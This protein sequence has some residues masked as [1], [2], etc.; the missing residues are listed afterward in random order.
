MRALGRGQCCAVGED[1]GVDHQQL[2]GRSRFAPEH[3]PTESHLSINV[4]DQLG[5]LRLADAVLE[6]RPKFDN[7]RILVFGFQG[8]QMQI[9]IDAQLAC[10]GC[11]SD[12]L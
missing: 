11:C 5:Q 4:Q 9:I 8:F 7:L 1:A 10:V 3:D 2:V 6:R 12:G